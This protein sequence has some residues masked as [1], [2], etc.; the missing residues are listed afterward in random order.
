MIR[1]A[2]VSHEYRSLWRP[3]R[4]VRALDGVSVEVTSG[5]AVGIIGLNGAGKTTLLRLLLGYLHPASGA[6][7]IANIAP[8]RYVETH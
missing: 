2:E 6:V 1:L 8:R 5:E 7:S 4:P 3:G